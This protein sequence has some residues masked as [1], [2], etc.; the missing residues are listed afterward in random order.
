LLRLRVNAFD[1]LIEEQLA[2]VRQKGPG[3]CDPT[4]LP[5]GQAVAAFIELVSQPYVDPGGAGGSSYR[6]A[7]PAA[8]ARMPF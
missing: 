3:Q 7:I 1:Q 6:G 8:P 5:N 2:S 4:A